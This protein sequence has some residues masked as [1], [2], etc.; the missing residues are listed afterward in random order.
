MTPT[1]FLLVVVAVLLVALIAGVWTIA[2]RLS[3]IEHELVARRLALG[4]ERFGFG[5][6]PLGSLG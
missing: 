2:W 1:Q 3:R 4:Q 6:G 5:L